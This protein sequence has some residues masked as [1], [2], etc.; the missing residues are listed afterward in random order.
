MS[1]VETIS[2]WKSDTPIDIAVNSNS[3]GIKIVDIKSNQKE[4]TI[5]FAITAK[6]A[7]LKG[8][9]TQDVIFQYK[10]AEGLPN[11]R[12][13]GLSFEKECLQII[14]TKLTVENISEGLIVMDYEVV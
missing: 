14:P 12:I 7:S 2:F 5:Q 10:S 1:K 9:E 13:F 4:Y 6:C 3:K 8:V 11:I